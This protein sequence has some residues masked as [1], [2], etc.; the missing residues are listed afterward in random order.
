MGPA[1]RRYGPTY[2]ITIAAIVL[3][4]L[5]V[6]GVVAASSFSYFLG[7][8]TGSGH[9]VTIQENVSGF[10][11]V[12]ISSG[13]RFTIT[14][15]AAYGVSVTI[16]DN[17][18]NY[19]QVIQTGNVLTIGF[20]PGHSISL[21][22]SSPS[23]SISM[24]DLAQLEISGGTTGTISGFALSHDFSVIA[25]GGSGVT[26][27]G[28]AVNL[29]VDA[30]G[31]SHVDFSNFPVTNANLDVSGG[32]QATVNVNGR[33]DASASGGSQ[34]Y[35]L[36]NPTLGSITATGGSAVTKK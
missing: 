18:V 4:A 10:N 26:G 21:I 20:T 24:P 13:F 19:V 7:G 16:D 34:V 14:Q 31:G 15:S 28:S 23:V 27:S 35:Y 22:F 36:G 2:W 12:I 17:L 29:T 8:V 30:S 3:A 5:I 33:L 1:R 6:I 11:H 9:L 32:T 25:S